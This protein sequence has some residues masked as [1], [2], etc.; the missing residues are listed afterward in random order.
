MRNGNFIDWAIGAN[1]HFT[2]LSPKTLL[3]M[4]DQ[5]VSSTYRGTPRHERNIDAGGRRD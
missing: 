3:R 4:L 5:P 2:S 1:L